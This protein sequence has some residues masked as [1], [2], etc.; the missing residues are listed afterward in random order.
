VAEDEIHYPLSVDGNLPMNGTFAGLPEGSQITLDNSSFQITYRGDDGKDVTLSP[1]QVPL[2]VASMTVAVGHGNG[3]VDP[4]ECNDLFVTL[5]NLAKLTV[6]LYLEHTSL[7]NIGLVLRNSRGSGISLAYR[8]GGLA[9]RF[10]NSCAPETQ[11]FVFDDDADVSVNDREAPMVGSARPRSPLS[12]FTGLSAAEVNGPWT[13]EVQTYDG[14]FNGTLHCWSLSATPAL[15]APG[16]GA[17]PACVATVT[18]SLTNPVSEPVTRFYTPGSPRLCGF[19]PEC[20]PDDYTP[21]PKRSYRVHAFT[22]DGPMPGFSF[23]VPIGARFDVVVLEGLSGPNTGRTD[24]ELTLYGLG[25][26]PPSL[27]VRPGI[28]PATVKV[29][30]SV[31]Y[32]GWRLEQG[33]ETAGF[34]AT[35]ET[36]SMVQGRYQVT[37]PVTPGGSLYRLAK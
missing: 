1:V 22:N 11:Q 36:P 6:S 8:A 35:P 20:E 37:R 34:S 18:N 29:S 23:S 31:T 2:R 30:W 32:P 28:T 5:T 25:C 19:V 14:P 13:L 21:P 9:D 15:V 3:Q 27:T 16:G 33:G 12:F 4:A 24:Y 17:C 10:G 26:P 7:T